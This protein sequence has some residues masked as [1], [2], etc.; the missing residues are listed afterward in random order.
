MWEKIDSFCSIVSP[1]AGLLLTLCVGLLVWL[2]RNNQKCS[3]ESQNLKC[4][5]RVIKN[6]RRH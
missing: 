5:A 1:W 2:I 4:S 3:K 6:R